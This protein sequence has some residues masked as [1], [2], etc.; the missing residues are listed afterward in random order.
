VKAEGTG[1]EREDDFKHNFN[2]N[3][4]PVHI[5]SIRCTGESCFT[6]AH[7]NL[8]FMW[9]SVAL[10][11]PEMNLLFVGPCCPFLGKKLKKII[12]S[13]VRLLLA[14]S[15]LFPPIAKHVYQL[16]GKTSN[17]RG[18]NAIKLGQD[19]VTFEIISIGLKNCAQQRWVNPYN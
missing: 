10:F 5:P 18:G 12:C 13:V 14:I 6:V 15:N 4:F 1:V 17:P 19:K 2:E 7:S 3:V 16:P 11:S 8:V 9:V